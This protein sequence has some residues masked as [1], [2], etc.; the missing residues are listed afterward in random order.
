[1]KSHD[2]WGG[3]GETSVQVAVAEFPKVGDTVDVTV[4]TDVDIEVIVVAEEHVVG[5]APDVI[6]AVEVIVLVV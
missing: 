5:E 3:G 1:L 6:V 2:A 4:D